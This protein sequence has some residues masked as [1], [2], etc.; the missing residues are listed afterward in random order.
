MPRVGARVVNFRAISDLAKKGV[1]GL[2]GGTVK[3]H[4]ETDK[5]AEVMGAAGMGAAGR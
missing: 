3:G 1:V 2:L 4:P 5:I